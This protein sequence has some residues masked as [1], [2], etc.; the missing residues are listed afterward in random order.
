MSTQSTIDA[1]SFAEKTNTYLTEYIKF[2]DAKAAAILTVLGI[3]GGVTAAAAK[4]IL[5]ASRQA[6]VVAQIAA[7]GTAG[8]VL[9]AATLATW[10]CLGALSPR[11]DSAAKSLHSFP[12]IALEDP[13]A[14]SA[15]IISAEREEL[16][17]AF[18]LHN[19]TLSRIARS[20]YAAI[21]S[22]TRCMT[23]AVIAAYVLAGIYGLSIV[24]VR[25]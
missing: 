1:G 25:P 11:T 21:S 8:A 9:L 2:A 24:W 14:Y 19:V 7:I 22:A 12:D 23:V 5:L 3:V 6:S 13:D 16:V 20:K 15:K 17:R 18:C 4:P 10:H